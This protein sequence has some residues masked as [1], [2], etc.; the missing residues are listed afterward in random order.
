MKLTPAEALE[1]IE[2]GVVVTPTDKN[3]KIY[4]GNYDKA[5]FNEFTPEEQQKFID[6]YNTRKVK[7]DYPYYFYVLPFFMKLAP[8]IE[9]AD[10]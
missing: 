2:K 5:Y 1:R 9:S 4:V 8:R 10:A 7:L 6:L 3:Y